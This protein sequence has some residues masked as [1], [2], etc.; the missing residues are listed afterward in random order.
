MSPQE[1]EELLSGEGR[2]QPSN[3]PA[4]EE[5]LAAQLK[6]GLYDLNANLAILKLYLL[7]PEESK[8]DVLEGILLKALMAFPETHFSL[9]MYQIPEKYH[10]SL[11]D[12]V[13]LAK[14]LEMS[15]FK[16]FWKESEGVEVL[17]KANGWQNAVRLF[18]ASV[19]SS[20][21]RSI[22]SDQLADL[23]NLPAGELEKLIKERGW[24]RSK[25]DKEVVVVNTASFESARVQIKAPTNLS[26]DQYRSLVMAASSA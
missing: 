23:L 25:D 13:D 20:T 8:V 19:V 2:Y 21:Y 15:K 14:Q 1:I 18:I 26:L 22:K 7:F 12:L 3:L 10:Q 11:R 9:C 24:S 5:H 4:L 16:T 6:E 17:A